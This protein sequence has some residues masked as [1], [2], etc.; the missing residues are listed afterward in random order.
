MA[1]NSDMMSMS[2]WAKKTDC[3]PFHNQTIHLHFVWKWR[4]N[5][6]QIL[7]YTDNVSLLLNQLFLY[8]PGR[9]QYTGFTMAN[10]SFFT[11]ITIILFQNFNYNKSCH[12]IISCILS[13]RKNSITID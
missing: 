5:I 1:F 6:F 13:R 7:K 12:V 3:Q 4:D 2:Q 11:I 8:W 10:V 9:T